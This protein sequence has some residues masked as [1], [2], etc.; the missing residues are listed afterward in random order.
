MGDFVQKS[1]TKTAVRELTAPIES[2]TAFNT[3]VAA[4]LSGPPASPTARS[5]SLRGLSLRLVDRG[6]GI[7]PLR[8]RPHCVRWRHPLR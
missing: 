1:V 7:A 4:I 2:I 6:P 3:I 5:R 8:R